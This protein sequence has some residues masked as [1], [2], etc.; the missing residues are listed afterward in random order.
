MLQFAAR[1]SVIDRTELGFTSAPCDAN[2]HSPSS[3]CEALVVCAIAY[4]RSPGALVLRHGKPTV[5]GRVSVEITRV[6]WAQAH[7]I[8]YP[9]RSH[10]PMVDACV[11][12]KPP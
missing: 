1:Y 3:P 11:V 7:V 10:A 8:A 2:E 12:G 9:D 5:N 6:I 4:V